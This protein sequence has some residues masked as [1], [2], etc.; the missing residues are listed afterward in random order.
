MKK[1]NKELM[2]YDYETIDISS[3]A[4]NNVTNITRARLFKYGNIISVVIDCAISEVEKA[5][6]KLPSEYYP[7]NTCN[8][9]IVNDNGETSR[10]YI[11]QINGN[12]IISPYISGNIHIN[13]AY[14]TK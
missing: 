10:L 13:G 6:F 11:S 9:S 8:L 5:I 7:A 2:N 12:M 3:Y 14:F 4:A 1:I